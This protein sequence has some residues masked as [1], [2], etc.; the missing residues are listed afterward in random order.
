[1][2]RGDAEFPEQG[3]RRGTVAVVVQADDAA[4]QADVAVPGHGGAGF[5][6]HAGADAGGD[7]ALAVIFV[8]GVEQL[9]AGHGYHAQEEGLTLSR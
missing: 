9:H 8:L 3:G 5:H 4:V 6:G 7:H 1:M 2:L